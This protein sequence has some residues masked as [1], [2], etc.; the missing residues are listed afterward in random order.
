MH[1][2]TSAIGIFV[3]ISLFWSVLFALNIVLYMKFGVWGSGALIAFLSV[4]FT[5]GEVYS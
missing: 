5:V 3:L 1:G 4:V 2:I